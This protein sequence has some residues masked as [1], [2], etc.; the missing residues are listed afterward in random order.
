M[1]P[2]SRSRDLALIPQ[3]NLAARC[4]Q[5]CDGMPGLGPSVNEEELRL[6]C[7]YLSENFVD[8]YPEHYLFR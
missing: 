4:S 7:K 3:P 8:Y 5:L 6:D 1:S 2:R